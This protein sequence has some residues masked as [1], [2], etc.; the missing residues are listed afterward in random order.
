MLKKKY[1]LALT[2]G[3]TVMMGINAMGA[4][5]QQDATGWW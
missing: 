5:W 2:A 4:G 3:L 1:A